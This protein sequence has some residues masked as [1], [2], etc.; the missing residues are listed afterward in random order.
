MKVGAAFL[1]KPGDKAVRGDVVF[2]GEWEPPSL[3]LRTFEEPV[4]E[5]PR[6]LFKPVRD[7]FWEHLPPLMNTDPFVY[8]GPFLYGNCKQNSRRGPTQ[9]QK[10]KRG[11][12]ILFG[13]NRHKKEF[14]LDTVLVVDDFVPYTTQ[15]YRSALEGRVIAEYLPLSPQVISYE[16]GVLKPGEVQGYRLYR[17]ATPDKPVGGMFSYFPCRPFSEEDAGFARPV[18]KKA[19]VVDDTLS[20]WQRMNPQ[21]SLEQVEA[22]WREITGQVLAQGLSLC[23]YADLP[24]DRFKAACDNPSDQ[25]QARAIAEVKKQLGVTDCGAAASKLGELKELELH[26]FGLKSLNFLSGAHGLEKLQAGNNDI[27]DLTFLRGMKNLVSLGLANNEMKDLSPIAGLKRLEW[28]MLWGGGHIV[29]ISVLAVLEHLETLGMNGTP[30]GNELVDKTEA[31]CPTDARSKVMREFCRETRKL[32]FPD[33]CTAEKLTGEALRTVGVLKKLIGSEDC[34]QVWQGLLSH[35]TLDLIEH[36]IENV[37][38][39]NNLPLQTLKLWG[40]EPH[41][42][43]V[44][45]SPFETA[46]IEELGLRITRIVEKRTRHGGMMRVTVNLSL[47]GKKQTV[48]IE[49]DN[50]GVVWEGYRVV[51]K[52]GWRSNATLEVTKAGE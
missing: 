22:L 20:G 27:T 38:P 43:R 32:H 50:E 1:G 45:L 52:S 29:D 35:A 24:E 10:L 8:G 16:Y 51:H 21:E 40:D 49:S 34:N 5:G 15:D 28:L 2:W 47:A 26:S 41:P 12:V 37:T 30:L 31:N 25:Y 39:L 48:N 17:G 6:Y 42:V 11:S 46:R 36:R 14:V 44:L 13:S 7:P 23:V 18:V 19:G 9:M 3:L 4:V 33:Y